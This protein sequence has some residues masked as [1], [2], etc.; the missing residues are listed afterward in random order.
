[1]TVYRIGDTVTLPTSPPMEY[2]LTSRDFAVLTDRDGTVVDV[3]QNWETA[4]SMVL[5][6]GVKAHVLRNERGTSMSRWQESLDAD[7]A[8]YNDCWG[9]T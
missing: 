1:M 2:L 6:Q 5:D 9:V 3:A 7:L 4:G 8:A